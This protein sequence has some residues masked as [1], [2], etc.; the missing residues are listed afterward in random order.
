MTQPKK[1]SEVLGI[2][3]EE[4]INPLKASERIVGEVIGRNKTIDEID[5]FTPSVEKLAEA[6]KM[7]RCGGT[8]E[9]D[10]DQTIHLV[11]GDCY[12]KKD[13]TKIA[14]LIIEN[15]DKWIVRNTQ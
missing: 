2:L 1:M 14:E 8:I 15:M 13:L 5:Q 10:Y 3:K 12:D 7:I 11:L 9:D 6:M 4:L